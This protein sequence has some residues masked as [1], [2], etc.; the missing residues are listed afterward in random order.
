MRMS[1]LFDRLRL[2]R[3]VE[4]LAAALVL[5]ALIGTPAAAFAYQRSQR[6]HDEAITLVGRT[7]M[8]G[9]WSER[10]ITVKQGETVRLRL[11]SDDVTHGFLLPEFGVDAGP[12]TPGKYKT[13]E[14]V[15]SEAG[16][17]TFYCNIMCSHEHGAM[18]GTLVVLP[19]G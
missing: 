6:A 17:F 16:T 5:L 19:A 13:V 12:I 3:K 14:F 4:W 10:T 7:P 8:D 9:N 11:T 2:G 15:A 1:Q 18:H